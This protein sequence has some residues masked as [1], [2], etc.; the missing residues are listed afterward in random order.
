MSRFEFQLDIQALQRDLEEMGRQAPI[1]MARALNRAA[2][3]GKAAMAAAIVKDTGIAAKNV[4]REI[5]LEKATRTKPIAAVVTEGRRIPLIAFQARGDES[6]RGKKKSKRARGVS[7]RSPRGAG[8]PREPHAFIA[9]VRG[10]TGME[11]N[12]RGVFIVKTAKIRSRKG[13]KR[14]SPQLPILEL[15]GPSVQEIFEKK[16]PVFNTAAR[17]SLVKNLA[18]EISFAKSKKTGD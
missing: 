11:G 2:V 8:R 1:I 14:G 15:Q 5:K 7:W 3:S 10:K 18:H 6:I 13:M 4:N 9:T 16:L 17:E 12:H